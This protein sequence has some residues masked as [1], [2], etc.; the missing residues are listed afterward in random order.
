MQFGCGGSASERYGIVP[1][2]LYGIPGVEAQLSWNRFDA[3]VQVTNSSPANPQSLRSRSQF[4]QGTAGAGY[5]PHGGLHIGVSG[6]QDHI[7]TMLL[8][9][10]FP[11]VNHLPIS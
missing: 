2:T 8:L 5:S 9:L 10:S 4:V 7:W 1:V 3:R 11:Q 6:F